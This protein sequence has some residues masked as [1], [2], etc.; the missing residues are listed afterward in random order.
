LDLRHTMKPPNAPPE[1][2]DFV[3]FWA[4]LGRVLVRLL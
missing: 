1:R 3:S 2:I 4:T